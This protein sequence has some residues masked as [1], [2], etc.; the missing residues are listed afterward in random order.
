MKSHLLVAAS[1]LALGACF[2]RGNDNDP[3]DLAAAP[4]DLGAD[5][6]LTMQEIETFEG[7]ADPLV[8]TQHLAVL[9]DSFFAFDPTIDPAVDALNNAQRIQMRMLEQLTGGDGGLCGKVSLSGTTVT[10]DFGTGCRL[11]SKINVSGNAS[12]RVTANAG[13][14][15]VLLTFTALKLNGKSLDG[16]TSFATST[17]TS[18]TVNA[19][20]TAAGLKLGATDFVVRGIPGSIILDSGSMT[21]TKLGVTTTLTFFTVAWKPLECYPNSGSVRIKLGPVVQTFV[22]DAQTPQTGVVTVKSGMK[23]VKRSLPAYGNCPP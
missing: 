13:T 12:A 5:E 8:I 4:L 15:T 3:P 1:V 20:L 21:A 23:S 6:T 22:F 18:F 16:T 11:L 10:V 7:G 17:G 2:L 14:I 9:A 19:D